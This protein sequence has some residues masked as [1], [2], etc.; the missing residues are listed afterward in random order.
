[1]ELESVSNLLIEIMRL[2]L[3]GKYKQVEQLTNGQRYPA[4]EL[5]NAMESHYEVLA[6]PPQDEISRMSIIK[7]NDSN[8]ESFATVVDFWTD[9]N[10]P[11]DLSLE[12]TF[13]RDE[14]GALFARIDNLHVM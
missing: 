9:K 13:I 6:M 3:D 12:C 5:K 7:I 8:E 4:I 2:L 14:D 11:S 1:M 10:E